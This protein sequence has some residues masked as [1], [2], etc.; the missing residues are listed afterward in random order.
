MILVDSNVPMDLVGVPHPHKVDARRL[1]ETAIAFGERLVT[2]AEVLQ[3][4]LHRYVA[5]GRPQDG[6]PK[7]APDTM[8]SWDTV[9]LVSS[10]DNPSVRQDRGSHAPDRQ[11]ARGRL[12]DV[13]GL[14]S[15]L[16]L[17]VGGKEGEAPPLQRT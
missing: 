15:D 8:T 11:A 3:E 10:H 14:G 4:V 6:G 12:R 1:L 5:I 17:R 9:R 7:V 2:D 13:G 16:P